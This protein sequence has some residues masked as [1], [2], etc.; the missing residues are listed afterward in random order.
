M[1]PVRER[2][3]YERFEEMGTTLVSV[4]YNEDLRHYH[5]Y[6]LELDGHG[7]WAFNENGKPKGLRPTP[8]MLYAGG[9]DF[10]RV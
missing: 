4:S 5:K 9:L 7:G 6:S 8:S 2:A 3:V 10:R 1:P